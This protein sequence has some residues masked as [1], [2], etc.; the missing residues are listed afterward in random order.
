ML[1]AFC[2]T[3]NNSSSSYV[4]RTFSCFFFFGF[5][6]GFWFRFSV[7]AFVCISISISNSIYISICTC[8]CACVSVQNTVV[9]DSLWQQESCDSSQQCE[10][11]NQVFYC[12]L[13]GAR[14]SKIFTLS[15]C[16]TCNVNV[17]LS[18]VCLPVCLI[19]NL[20]HV[21]ALSF[22]YPLLPFLEPS[23]SVLFCFVFPDFPVLFGSCL[24]WNA[25]K[26]RM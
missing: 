9:C 3:L 24:S 14:V 6:F 4:P 21:L 20:Q 22:Y 5:G 2:A 23:F 1:D 17:S 19:N 18:C 12:L 11:H 13:L 25:A 16:P 8:T 7:S 10:F 15:F 26:L